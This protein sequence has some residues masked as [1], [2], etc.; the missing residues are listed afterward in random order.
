[1]VEVRGAID[2]ATAPDLDTHL[3]A[4][5]SRPGARVVVD[6]RQA[7]FFDCS[8]LTVLCRARLRVVEQGGFLVLVC[9]RPWHLRVLRAAG[10]GR[11]FPSAVTVDEALART[12]TS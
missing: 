2:L 4:A 1:M 12:G 8:A 3:A 5:A 11:I 10:L 7:E 6:L 9:V